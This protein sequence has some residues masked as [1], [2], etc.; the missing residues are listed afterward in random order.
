[1][2]AS[3]KS[4]ILAAAIVSVL[5]GCAVGNPYQRPDLALPARWDGA[6]P[7]SPATA[8]AADVRIDAEWWRRF[9]SK[10]LDALMA[11]AL[12][13][14]HDL[15]AALARIRQSR[16]ATDIARAGQLPSAGVSA[17][18]SSSNRHSG[19]AVSGDR[20]SS[21][22]NASVSYELD[23]WG[24]NAARS[25]AA[26]ARLEASV[27]DRDAVA[28]VL[29]ADVA[30]NYFQIL[31]LKER[32]AIARQNLEAAQSVL[33]LV[34]TRFRNG[35]NSGLEVSQ[36]RTS[37]LNIQAQIPALEQD[38]RTA[39]TALAV[40]LGRAPQGFSV[41]GDSLAALRLPLVA[42]YQPAALLERRPDIARAEAQLVAANADIGAARAVLY[43]SITLSAGSAASGLLSGG[44]SVVS[45]LA[46]SL[47]QTI[48]DGGA[49]RGQVAQSEARQAELVQ[50]YLQNVLTGLK[51]VQDSLGAVDA[52][53]ARQELL[54]RAVGEAR[55]AY[56]IAS[57]KYKAG[58]EDLLTL[59]DSQRTQL[60]AQDS[61]VQADLARYTSAVSLY[62]SL[63]GGW[64]SGKAAG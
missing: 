40:L 15:G 62:K 13:A 10:E 12:A 3:I 18:A 44:T 20:S 55:E 8:P 9:G 24:G 26:T 52:S 17:G 23:L 39:Q 47:A 38:L 33:A 50:S 5:A 27:Y 32:L 1:M 42:A 41:H 61:R 60:Q 48:F 25:A 37:V 19:A 28:L 14:N 51:E 45:S 30:S 6:T 35:A 11:Q 2:R 46:A 16:A 63:G 21:Q 29:Q 59:L 4:G 7:T 57:V 54:A 43:P 58:A 22:L 53:A 34:E 36:Q 49:L 56:R 31:A 64:D